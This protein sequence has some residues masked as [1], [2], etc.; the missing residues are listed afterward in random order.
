MRGRLAWVGGGGCALAEREGNGIGGG[1]IAS[2]D[3][4]ER[5]IG[6]VGRVG[7][8]SRSGGWRWMTGAGRGQVAGT[9]GGRAA[10]CRMKVGGGVW[11]GQRGRQGGV[12]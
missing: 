7:K 10:R 2:A 3:W 4:L 9:C 11:S 1:G 5:P 8:R 6:A 12:G